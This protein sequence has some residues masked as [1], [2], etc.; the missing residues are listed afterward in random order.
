MESH[1]FFLARIFL[2]QKASELAQ[3]AI[4]NRSLKV[5]YKVLDRMVMMQGENLNSLKSTEP[6]LKPRNSS[7]SQ[8]PAL[9]MLL[10]PDSCPP[11]GPSNSIEEISS[12]GSSKSDSIQSITPISGD[13]RDIAVAGTT[14]STSFDFDFPRSSALPRNK[15]DPARPVPGLHSELLSL[16]RYHY[17]GKPMTV[18]ER[19]LFEAMGPVQLTEKW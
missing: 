13:T 12:G 8:H 18:E 17:G 14:A 9:D 16:W 6:A 3:L 2:P 5:K 19:Q 7:G 15:N 1:T 10:N 11:L 4:E